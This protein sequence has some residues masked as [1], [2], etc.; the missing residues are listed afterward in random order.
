MVK[1]P[2]ENAINELV[3]AFEPYYFALGKTAHAWN[4][5]QEELAQLFSDLTGTDDLGL[6]LW[7]TLRSDR[8]QR[9]LLE[10]ALKSRLEDEE[11]REKYP[12]AKEDIGWLLTECNNLANRRNDAVHAPCTMG[13]K[14]GQLEI[15]P[16]S[17]YRNP[18]AQ[19]LKGKQILQEFAWYEATADTLKNFAVSLGAVFRSDRRSWP[20]TPKLPTLQH[21]SSRAK[22]RH[23]S[24]CKSK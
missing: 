3:T 9:D 21:K 24:V 23:R 20:E 17:F 11:W 16:F 2:D 6:A 22:Q 14:S 5:L 13:I 12:R 10:A 8:G 1:L 15:V 19:A 4:H 18:R 7:H